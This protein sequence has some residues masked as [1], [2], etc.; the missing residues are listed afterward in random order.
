MT[1]TAFAG[2]LVTVPLAAIAFIAWSGRGPPRQP[3]VEATVRTAGPEAPAAAL[4]GLAPR[5]K[6]KGPVATYDE[7]TLFDYIDGAAPIYLARHFRRLTA[8]ELVLSDGGEVTADLYDMGAPEN[9]ASILEAER[10]G[11]GRA[12]EG[13][14]AAIAGP[15]SFVFRRG[16]HYVKLTGFDGRAE[17]AL[18]EIARALDGRLR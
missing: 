15:M 9:A 18:P 3:R 8:A 10:S 5:A 2:L 13:F 7:R 12:V 17:A 16:R 11:A 6:L 4:A 14:E 1:R